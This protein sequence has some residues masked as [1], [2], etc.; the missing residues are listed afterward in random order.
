[1]RRSHLV[2]ISATPAGSD[3]LSKAVPITDTWYLRGLQQPSLFRYENNPDAITAAI[4]TILFNAEITS[5]S[6]P[7]LKDAALDGQ[8]IRGT[9]FGFPEINLPPYIAWQDP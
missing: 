4:L 8:A 3:W 1:M 2:F 9:H 7:Y 5:R 6:N